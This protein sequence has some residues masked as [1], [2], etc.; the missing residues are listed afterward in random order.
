[1]EPTELKEQTDEIAEGGG[2]SAFN[3]AVAVGVVICAVFMALCKVKDDNIVQAMQAAQVEKLDNW[4]YYQANSMKQ[5]MFEL[6][7]D[8]AEL[9]ATANPAIRTALD[10]KEKRWRTQIE[11]YEKQKAETKKK[12]EDSGKLYDHLNFRDDQFDLS[13]T[14]LGLAVALFALASLTRSKSVFGFASLI[15]IG[16]IVMGLAGFFEWGI[17]PGV[18]RFLS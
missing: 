7:M 10:E 3:K 13:D 17:H 5:H 2:T 16:G 12:A 9:Q 4:G 8:Q 18:I 1:M 11:K 14:L 15:A 6:Q